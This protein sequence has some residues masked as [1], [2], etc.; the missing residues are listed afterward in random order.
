[1]P[2]PAPLPYAIDGVPSSKNDQDQQIGL[3]GN[4]GRDEYRVKRQQEDHRCHQPTAGIN[5]LDHR[6][7]I[8]DVLHSRSHQ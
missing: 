4:P 8:A 7:T 6:T 3:P 1:M 5:R 2:R